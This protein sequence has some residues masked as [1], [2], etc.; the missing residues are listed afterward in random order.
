VTP[1]PHK[2]EVTMRLPAFVEAFNALPPGTVLEDVTVSVA[3][4][5][6]SSRS[7]SA[8]LQF[9]DLHGEG[10]KIQIMFNAAYASTPEA[11]EWSRDNVR[12]GDIVGAVG[13]PGKTKLGELSIVPSKL[14]VLTPCL[15]MMPKSFYGLKDQ[16]TRYRQ[17]YLDI[18]LNE[19]VRRTFQNRAKVINYIRRFLDTRHFLEVETPMMNMLPGGCVRAAAVGPDAERRGCG[20][21]SRTR[22]RGGA[23]PLATRSSPP[24][25][26][27]PPP[28]PPPLAAPPRAPSSRT[29][30][31]WTWTCSCAS[32]PSCTSSSS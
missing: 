18:M 3:G 23:L 22:A 30:T 25:L 2:F 32:R 6:M 19:S 14:Q 29:T 24:T 7:S 16:E 31:T 17:R 4:R 28:H 21:G 27:P 10:A 8:K 11:Y 26:M 20:G 1:Y 13:H 9:Y 15:H 5:L 12:R